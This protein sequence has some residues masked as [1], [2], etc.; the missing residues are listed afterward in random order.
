MA[1]ETGEERKEMQEGVVH[2]EKDDVKERWKEYEIFY[3]KVL[4]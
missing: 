3:G 4:R 1:G 2:G